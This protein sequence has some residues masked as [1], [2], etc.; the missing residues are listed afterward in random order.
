MSAQSVVKEEDLVDL[1]AIDMSLPES[2]VIPQLIQNLRTIGFFTLKNVEGFDED[3][4]FR[5]VHGFYKDVPEE[6][7][8][9]L[10]WQNHCPDN[11]NYFRGLIPFVEN[12]PAHKELYD[13]GGSLSLV[14]DEALK[15][16]FYEQTP[17]P[18]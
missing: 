11:S 14:S 15:H 5:A 8:R 10:V 7:R 6:E 13:M 16:A 3:E 1:Q 4:L 2:E 9:K 17:F 12:D 18:P